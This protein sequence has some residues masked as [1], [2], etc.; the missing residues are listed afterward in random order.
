MKVMELEKLG[1]V[2]LNR[3]EIQLIDGGDTNGTMAGGSIS[4]DWTK[5][6]INFIVG[7]V[8]GVFS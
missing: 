6:V 8:G 1:M 3:S 7:F 2:E 5:P 4:L